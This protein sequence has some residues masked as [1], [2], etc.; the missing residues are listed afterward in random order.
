MCDEGCL[1]IDGWIDGCMDGWMDGLRW[2]D[3]QI[4]GWMDVW[5]DGVISR[6][7]APLQESRCTTGK[8]WHAWACPTQSVT[9]PLPSMDVYLHDAKNQSEGLTPSRYISDK[10]LPAIS[11]AEGIL[12]HNLRTRH[13]FFP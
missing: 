6:F 4:D 8:N 12:G 9:Q 1:E 7:T 13:V 5:M 11:F 3:G 10:R 2:M